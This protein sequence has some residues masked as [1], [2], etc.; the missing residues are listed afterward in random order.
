MSFP[1]HCNRKI[2]AESHSICQRKIP[3][4]LCQENSDGSIFVRY[5]LEILYNFVEKSGKM[6]RV[7]A[8]PKKCIKTNLQQPANS[9]VFLLKG[10]QIT[11][12]HT[13]LYNHILYNITLCYLL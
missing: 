5:C 11:T 9:W 10:K 8:S 1:V 4:R 7:K 13:L 12:S 2:Y 6:P 3:G